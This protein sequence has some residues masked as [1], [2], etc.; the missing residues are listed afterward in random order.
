MT[1]AIDRIPIARSVVYAVKGA[2][3]VPAQYTTGLTL[4]P[5]EITLTYRSAPDGQLGRVHAYVKGWWMRDG[6]RYPADKPVGQHYY[7]DVGQWPDWLAAEARLHDPDAATP[8]GRAPA[9][10]RATLH[11]RIAALFRHPPGAERLGDTTP[12]EIA[13]AVLAVL[14][15]PADRATV[16]AAALREGA[17]LLEAHASTLELLSS[18]DYDN[19]AFAASHLRTKAAELRRMAGEAPHTGEQP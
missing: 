6:E 1:D 12:G 10:D 2:P 14:P 5:T 3:E 15:A 16:R 17:V 7:S 8:A 4:A 13:D 18:S 9:A 19:E 11:D